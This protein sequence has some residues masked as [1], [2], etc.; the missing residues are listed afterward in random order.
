[1]FLSKWDMIIYMNIS[2]NIISQMV[3]NNILMNILRLIASARW[4]SLFYCEYFS[5]NFNSISVNSA[6]LIYSLAASGTSRFSRITTYSK[7]DPSLTRNPY[8]NLAAAVVFLLT[9]IVRTAGKG[10]ASPGLYIFPTIYRHST[11]HFCLV[12]LSHNQ[13]SSFNVNA[14]YR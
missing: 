4:A 9:S 2:W 3:I 5:A 7:N 10:I 1:M 6:S 13:W 12:E 8:V 14:L 11:P